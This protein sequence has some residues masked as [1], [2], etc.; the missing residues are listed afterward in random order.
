MYGVLEPPTAANARPWSALDLII[1]K[2]QRL[3]G[4]GISE[5][6]KFVPNL[7]KVIS[8]AAA[9]TVN[10]LGPLTSLIVIAV[11]VLPRMSTIGTNLASASVLKRSRAWSEN[12]IRS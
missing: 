2:G 7:E 9:T 5:I 12:W 8:S 3:F 1:A 10:S 6:W 11:V 4:S